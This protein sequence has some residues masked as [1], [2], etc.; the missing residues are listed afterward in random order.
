M[1]EEFSILMREMMVI[2][3]NKY[4]DP[5]YDWEKKQAFIEGSYLSDM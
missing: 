4:R 1:K 3:Y 2:P 5:I